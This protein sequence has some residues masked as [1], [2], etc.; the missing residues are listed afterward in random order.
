MFP[1]GCFL[2]A[3]SVEYRAQ[4]RLVAARAVEEMKQ[5]WLDLIEDELQVGAGKARG[6]MTAPDE[7]PSSLT[8]S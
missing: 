5:A 7:L 8:R 4:T 6:P 1:G 2:G 3:T